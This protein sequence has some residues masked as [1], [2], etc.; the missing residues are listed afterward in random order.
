VVTLFTVGVP[1][2]ALAAWARPAPIPRGHLMGSLLHFVAPAGSS[3]AFVGL[4]FYVAYLVVTGSAELAQSAL[5][6]LAVFSG[7]GLL[8][9]ASP[10]RRGWTDAAPGGTRSMALAGVLLVGFVWVAL[11]PDT[12][13]FFD[14]GPLSEAD[15]AVAAAVSIAWVVAL[16]WIWRACLLERLLGLELPRIAEDAVPMARP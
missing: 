8:L 7:I 10:P 1:A 3:L 6:A 11:H 4:V 14:L 12:S 16:R 2:I 9:L 5:T 13:R 15:L